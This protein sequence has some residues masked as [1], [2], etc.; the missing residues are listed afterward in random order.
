MSK[1]H[2]KKLRNPNYLGSWDLAK[3]DG[4][5]DNAILTI[6]GVSKELVHDGQGG[7]DECVVCSFKESK[8]MILNSTNINAISKA[9]GSPYIEDW[10]G[11]KIEVFV[12]KVKA[13]GEYHDALRIV[14]KAPTVPKKETKPQLAMDKVANV[15]AAISEGKFTIDQ[16]QDMYTIPADV[17]K[18]IQS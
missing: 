2:F 13:F 16:I 3:E 11:R 15:R 7:Q 17:L 12:K 14:P 1:T 4:T 10:T 8:P 9:C 6:A 18:A 5:F